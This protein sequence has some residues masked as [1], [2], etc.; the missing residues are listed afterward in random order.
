VHDGQ[1]FKSLTYAVIVE[2]PIVHPTLPVYGSD[3]MPQRFE[4]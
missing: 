1:S 4:L 2:Y 3:L